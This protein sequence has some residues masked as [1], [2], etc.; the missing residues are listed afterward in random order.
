MNNDTTNLIAEYKRRLAVME[1]ATP[2]NVERHRPDIGSDVWQSVSDPFWDWDEEN[3]R[4][5]PEP[6]YRAWTLDEVPVGAVVR[7]KQTKAHGVAD[8]VIIIGT[9]DGRVHCGDSLDTTTCEDLL[10]EAE[11]S[12]DFCKTW[13]PCGVLES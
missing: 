4:I 5:K 8:R 13:Q 3:Y 11:V 9:S 2:H 6:K 1:A 7:R 12:Y 10:Q